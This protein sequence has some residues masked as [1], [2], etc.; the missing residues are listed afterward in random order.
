MGHEREISMFERY[1]ENARRVIFFARREASQYGSPRIETEHL[2]LGILKESGVVLRG[3][4]PANVSFAQIRDKIDSSATSDET[5]I[6]LS[7]DMPLSEHCTKILRHAAEEA[8]LLGDDRVGPEHLLLGTLREKTGLAARVL[9]DFGV[10][11]EDTR[12]LL[13][14]LR[15]KAGLATRFLWESG[16]DLEEFRAVAEEGRL[17]ETEAAAHN[18]ARSLQDAWN[19]H[20]ADEFASLFDSDAEY[21]AANGVV[22]TG[23]E[24]I[25]TALAALFAGECKESIATLSSCEVKM[26][27]P[28][29]AVVRATWAIAGDTRRG[30]SAATRMLLVVSQ[31]E[32]EWKIVCLQ[33]TTIE[34]ES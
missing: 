3:L 14:V 17:E 24:N 23:R 33:N 6:S 20:S 18:I 26:L 28:D 21:G 10:E 19:R 1:T 22:W 30:A 27:R 29:V 25:R 4:F 5:P 11:L 31:I 2:L 8:D 16:I 7:V 9:R 13:G 15:E 32:G 34:Q 12:R